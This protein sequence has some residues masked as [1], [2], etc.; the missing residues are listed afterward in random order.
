MISDVPLGIHVLDYLRRGELKPPNIVEMTDFFEDHIYYCIEMVPYGLPG[1]DL[2]D[3]IEMRT[4]MEESECKN[5]FLQVVNA[6]HTKALVVHRDIKDEN[7]ILDSDNKVKLANFGSA[8]YIK[9][10][11]FDVYVG[12]IGKIP[13]DCLAPRQRR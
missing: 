1:V 3:Y 2:F 12:T 7:I 10:A 8:A 9:N 13:P 5:T 11:P 4:N 6:L